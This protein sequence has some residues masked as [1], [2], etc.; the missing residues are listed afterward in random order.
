MHCFLDIHR[1][2][3][4]QR[5]K[6]TTHTMQ[7][8]KSKKNRLTYGTLRLLLKGLFDALFAKHMPAMSSAWL[9]LQSMQQVRE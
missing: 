8:K 1:A 5:K 7:K 3:K 9:L 6:H 4:E 2:V